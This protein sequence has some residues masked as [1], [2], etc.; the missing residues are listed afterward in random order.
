M[1]RNPYNYHGMTHHGENPDKLKWFTQPDI[2]HMEDW[3]YFLDKLKSIQPRQWPQ[4]VV[5]IFLTLPDSL[6]A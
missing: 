6:F 3:A 5:T 1:C 2:W 4:Q